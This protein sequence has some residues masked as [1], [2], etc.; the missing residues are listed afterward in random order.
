VLAP[1]SAPP[2]RWQVLLYVAAALTLLLPIW[3]ARYVPTGDGPSHVYSAWVLLHLDD[4]A[5]PH[6]GDHFTTRLEP[7]PNWTIQA[8][9]LLLLQVAPPL[10]AE[11]L[12]LSLYVL[13]FAAAAWYFAATV[14]RSRAANAFLLL[15]FAYHKLLYWGFYNFAFGV[16]LLFLA[17]AYW[18]RH[19]AIP[20]ARFAVVLNL[21]LLLAYFTHIVTLA[22]TLIAIA[23]LWLATARGAPLRR[24]AL[25][26]A[27][28]APQCLLPLWFVASQQGGIIASEAPARVV[29][30]FVLRLGALFPHQSPHAGRLLGLLLLALAAATLVRRNLRGGAGGWRPRLA[31]EGDGFLLVAA[32][33]TGALVAAPAGVFEG[34]ILPLRLSLFPFLALV[35]W[36]APASS[37]A[38]PAVLAVALSGLVAWQA[39][40]LARFHRG[41]EGDLA[42]FLAGLEDVAPASRVLPIVFSR[43]HDLTTRAYGHLISW[44]AID[45]A[46]VD[47]DNY[48]AVS[49]YF[50][51]RFRAG[52]ARP[53]LVAVEAQPERYPV[54]RHLAAVDY[55]YTWHMP[56][57]SPL[58]RRLE[59]FYAPVARSGDGELFARR[60]PGGPP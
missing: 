20:S 9:L 3:S 43:E 10:V 59:R 47:W 13:G 39:V 1:A 56:A 11:K 45:K 27:I 49:P 7:L 38:V 53:D 50:P 52:L 34:T 28:L 23:A 35:P 6:L 57:T 29:L 15:P 32:L 37:R 17:V 41:I 48:Q 4:P 21:L 18:W 31:G 40:G 2:P 25:H 60:R 8:L 12:L 58:R 33:F 16:P 30:A 42:T 51:I 22:L 46:L 44:A 19:R 55:V 14:E 24:H 36:L 5:L 26:L 54:R